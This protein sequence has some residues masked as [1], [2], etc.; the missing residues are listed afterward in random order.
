MIL[1]SKDFYDCFTNLVG[2][3]EYS[4]YEKELNE[5]YTVRLLHE[6][7]VLDAF[8]VVYRQ[9]DS[10]AI[11]FNPLLLLNM[12][13]QEEK[14]GN[15]HYYQCALFVAVKLTHEIAHLLH[16]QCVLRYL[17]PDVA[18]LTPKTIILD[19]FKE[20]ISNKIQ[21]LDRE[22]EYDDLGEMIELYLFGG[23]VAAKYSNTENYMDIEQCVLYGSKLSKI[24]NYVDCPTT[25]NEI[26]TGKFQF[27]LGEEIVSP[28]QPRFTRIALKS[29][30]HRLSKPDS[31]VY[32]D[33]SDDE[34][35]EDTEEEEEEIN[36][37]GN[38]RL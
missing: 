26:K 38:L 12:L 31:D 5:T 8:C 17:G 7:N 19:K 21:I 2:E 20:K 18:K 16:Y 15:R 3:V 14:E 10:K 33:R 30:V 13:R 24:G 4:L 32:G 36:K 29:G 37:S 23:V 9:N 11:Y 6:K 25:I 34:D 35:G 22:V 28:K 27:I 1:K